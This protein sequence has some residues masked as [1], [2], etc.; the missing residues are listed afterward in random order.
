MIESM[1]QRYNHNKTEKKGCMD[2]FF[3]VFMCEDLTLQGNV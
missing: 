1:K 2:V 3:L